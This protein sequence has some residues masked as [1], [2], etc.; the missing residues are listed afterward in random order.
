MLILTRSNLSNV[1][2]GVQIHSLTN[3]EGLQCKGPKILQIM[4]KLF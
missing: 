2:I 4:Y 3:L 1:F